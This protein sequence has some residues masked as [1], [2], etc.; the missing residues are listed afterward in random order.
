M[1]RTIL[2]GTAGGPAPKA[3]RNAPAQAIVVDGVTYVVDCGNGVARQLTLAGIPLDTVRAAFVTH[4]HSDHNADLG[5]LP[6]LAWACNLEQVMHLYGPPPT[7]EMIGHFLAMN[8]FD[9]DTRVVDEGLRRLDDLI[10]AHDVSEP[11][12]VYEDDRVRVTCVKVH[13]PPIECALAYRFD[14]A[15]TSVVF[16]GDTA[17]NDALAQLAE[18]ADTLVH[19]AMHLPSVET[20][21]AMYNAPTLRDH[22]LASHT[23]A[24]DAGRI[25][26]RAGVRRLVLS[27][28]VPSDVPISDEQWL[29][30]ARST[31]DG[32]VVVGRDLLVLDPALAAA[33]RKPIS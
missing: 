26:N 17:P 16:S 29:D 20:M 33:E 27:H 2:L 7:R 10:E 1:T 21:V 3:G 6:L 13:H 22:L 24:E 31:F 14:T 28:L 19:E 18:G 4:H 25:A 11:G 30:C 23:S 8:R 15:D 32:E 5:T 12:L 9:I